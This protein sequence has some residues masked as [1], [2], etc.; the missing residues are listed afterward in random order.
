MSE[1]RS[2]NH[3]EH[4]PHIPRL[5]RY[6]SELSP[7]PMVAV[8]GETHVINYVNPAFTQLVGKDRKDL[9]DCPFYQAVP[10]GIENECH[11]L[12]DRVFRT[13][14]AEN[15]PEQEHRQSNRQGIYWSYVMW[16]ILGEDQRPVGVTIQ[17][18]D[19]TE[20]ANFRRQAVEIN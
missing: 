17:I 5:C 7:Q 15:L 3:A 11:V 14:V 6:L 19:A 8:D 16:A 1:K 18:T 20:T 13:G 12:L 4:V 10:E 2:S 9:I